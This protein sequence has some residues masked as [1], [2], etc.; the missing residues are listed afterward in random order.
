M[1]D[2]KELQAIFARYMYW[3]DRCNLAEAFI[4]E[5][6][7]EPDTTPEQ[8]NAWQAWMDFIKDNE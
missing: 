5:T 8:A 7:T 1:E 2:N 4:R 6:P 3:R